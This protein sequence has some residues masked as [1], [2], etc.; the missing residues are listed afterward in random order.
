VV[1]QRSKPSS[2]LLKLRRQNANLTLLPR[3]PSLLVTN[4]AR[5]LS[6]R[7]IAL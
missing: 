7:H 4:P 2:R 5:L 1:A 3:D 6:N